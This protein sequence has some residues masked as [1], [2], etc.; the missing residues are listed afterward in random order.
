MSQRPAAIG[1]LVC[2][3]VII[4][5]RTRNVTPV[6]CFSERL[7]GRFPSEPSSF[8]VFALLNDGHGQVRLDWTLQR[9]DNLE[10][11]R[12]I[13]GDAVFRDQ[14]HEVRCIVRMRNLSF[15]VAGAYLVSLLADDEIIAQRK[16]RVRKKEI[17]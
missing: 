12:R 14:L 4:E 10:E 15:P 13:S 1:I 16:F 17:S 6:N 2:E 9:L 11:L 5:E 3:Q 8:H 7:V